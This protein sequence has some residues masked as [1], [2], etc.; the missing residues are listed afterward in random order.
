MEKVL[1]VGQTPPPFGGQ[2]LMIE[3]LIKNNFE[4]VE[5]F[6]VRLAFSQDM[7][8]VGRFQL[9]KLVHLVYVISAIIYKRIRHDIRILYYPPAGPH[10]IPMFRDI[11]ILASTRWLFEKTVFHF[12]AG[13]ISEL[14]PQLPPLLKYL[15]RKAYWNP[16]AAILLSDR[17]PADGERLQAR[18]QWVIPYGIEDHSIHY[19]NNDFAPE[20]GPAQILYV[21]ILRESKGILILIEACRIL[22]EQGFSFGLN[23][24]GEFASETFKQTALHKVASCQLEKQVR[25]LGVLTGDDKWRQFSNA[26]IFCFPSFFESET[27]G[28]VV[29]EAMQFRLSVVATWWR[30]IPS[31][32]RDGETGY[33]V[34]IKDP[35]ALAENIAILLQNPD[36]AR[37]MGHKGR[38][39]YLEYFT[40][41][42]YVTNIEEVFLSLAH[43]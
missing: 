15:Y 26:N 1:I 32:V 31:L 42:K 22:Q 2:A 18:T 29:L 38:E 39:V 23:L 21:G 8:E 30:G 11:A 9:K 14:Y 16:D 10:K 17:N 40:I 36:K 27:F 28:L 35:E 4:N 13:G 12:H 3:R 43:Q 5:L 24:V 41:D 34:P 37:E 25:F 7:S 20:P 33:L 6:H 19:S